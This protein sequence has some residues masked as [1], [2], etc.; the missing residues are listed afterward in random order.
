MYQQFDFSLFVF[1][2]FFVYGLRECYFLLDTDLKYMRTTGKFEDIGRE[3]FFH[4][5]ISTR[6]HV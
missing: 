5:E 6:V 3:F 4:V 1:L 2:L